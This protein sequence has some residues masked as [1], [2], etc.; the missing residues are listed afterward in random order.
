MSYGFLDIAITPSVRAAQARMASDHLWQDFKGHREFNRF[1]QAVAQFIAQRDSFYMATIS[2][3]GWPYIQHRGGPTG[4]LRI[5]DPRTLAFAD[6]RRSQGAG[7]TL[8][9]PQDPSAWNGKLWVMAH[10][11]GPGTD[12]AWDA[13]LDGASERGAGLRSCG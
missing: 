5:L 8:F 6:Y 3:N 13:G 1:T 2:E 9:Y 4:F 12:R 10:G 11:A 7:M